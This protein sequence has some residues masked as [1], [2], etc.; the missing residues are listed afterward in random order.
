MSFK[1]YILEAVQEGLSNPDAG[2][3][4]PLK[5]LS[6][7]TNYIQKGQYTAIGGKP[8]SGKSSMMDYVYMMNIYRWWRDLDPNSKPKLKM[9]YFNMKTRPK[10][11]WQK[12]LCLFLK[13]EYGR[14]IDIPTLTSGVGRLY[15]L[16]EQILTEIETA[17]EF[18]EEFESEVLTMINGQQTP[19][20][21]KNTMTEYMEVV[22]GSDQD[23]NYVLNNDNRNQI[24]FVYIDNTDLLLTESDGY[25]QMNLDGLKKKLNEYILELRAK[26]N[27]GFTVIV[28]SKVSNSRMVKDSEPTYKELGLF[29]KSVDLGLVMYNPYNEN[30]RGYLG[31][32]VEEM[33]FNGKPR[34][35]TVS[36]VRNEGLENVTVGLVFIG[37]CG[38]IAETPHP[39]LVDQFENLQDSLS[40]L[41]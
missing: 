18:F 32:P 9:F 35:R 23:D 27:I 34:L 10:I 28:P 25:S 21:I 11:K 36:V 20:S 22:G 5:K 7:F 33:V 39:E 14:V 1:N 2:I 12:W 17:K 8:T 30:N 29:A 13:L 41:A 15:D 31:Y 6:K 4:V 40:N 19:S 26:Y 37:E 38:Y 16:D 3:P 24:T